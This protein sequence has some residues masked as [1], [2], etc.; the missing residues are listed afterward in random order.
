MGQPDV[1]IVSGEPLWPSVHG[2]RIRTA[3]MLEALAHH[4]AVRVAAPLEAGAPHGIPV[5]PL[6][7]PPVI[8][9][10]RLAASAAPALGGML[11]DPERA[12]AV[13]GLVARHRP[14][15][16][17]LAQSYLA[18]VAPTLAVPIAVDF[19]DVEVRR[20]VSLA[21]SAPSRHARV[22]FGLEAAKA[23]RWEPRLARSATVVS[24]ASGADAALL[25]S[26]GAA[27]VL[28]PN[29]AATFDYTP[30]PARGPVTLVANF[31]YQPNRDA[32]RFVLEAL[33]PRL[34]AAADGPELRLRAVGRGPPAPWPPTTG[35][36][37]STS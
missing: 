2:G 14:R 7:G 32:A 34:R 23:R 36:R 24:T 8:R 30:S 22:A 16:V 6:P 27:P 1:L 35:P 4:L 29:G 26:W 13:A 11:L 31:A 9:R 18:A 33:W 3:R 12:R 37:G 28:V 17:L 10:W 19:P 20:M 25:T 15:T 5:D 21:G